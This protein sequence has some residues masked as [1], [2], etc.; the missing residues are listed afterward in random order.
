MLSLQPK[1]LD[2][3]SPQ[4]I[5]DI[6]KRLNELSSA[7]AHLSPLTLKGNLG[8]YP[9]CKHLQHKNLKL[10]ERNLILDASQQLPF[11]FTSK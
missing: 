1:R 3:D 10:G 7:S 4:L 5:L 11:H 9:G 6:Y 8:I 2:W